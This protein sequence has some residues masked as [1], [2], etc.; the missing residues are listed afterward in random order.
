MSSNNHI[1]SIFGGLLEAIDQK[2][3]RAYWLVV[4][5][6]ELTQPQQATITSLQELT[7][8]TSTEEFNNVLKSCKLAGGKGVESRWKTFLT[9]LSIEKF[10]FVLRSIYGKDRWVSQIEPE[11]KGFYKDATTQ[12]GANVK[13]PTVRG[14]IISELRAKLKQHFTAQHNNDNANST[15]EANANTNRN[16]DTSSQA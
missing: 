8:L 13:V 14:R 11:S 7:Q 1:S 4:W 2:L 3:D 5:G 16:S 15:S 6:D 10:E 12:I 9:S